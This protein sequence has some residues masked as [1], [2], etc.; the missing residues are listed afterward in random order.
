M[1]GSV[2]SKALLN[3]GDNV[4]KNNISKERLPNSKAKYNY[5]VDDL[6]DIRRIKYDNSLLDIEMGNIK[7]NT[8]SINTESINTEILIY[9]MWRPIILL[10]VLMKLVITMTVVLTMMILKY[11]TWIK[12]K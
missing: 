5:L 9:L 4:T 1:N 7:V 12:V 10:E 3:N 6:I 11:I 2:N 8:E